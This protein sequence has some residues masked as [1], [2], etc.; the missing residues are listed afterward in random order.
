MRTILCPVDF[1]PFAENALVFADGLASLTGAKLLILH[2]FSMPEGS[3]PAESYF[4]PATSQAGIN[5][6][7][8]EITVPKL[9][10]IVQRLRQAH[11]KSGVQYEYLIRYGAATSEIR[12]VANEKKADLIVMG[13]SGANGLKELLEGTLTA[14]VA[15]NAHCPVL[16]VPQKAAYKSWKHI[17]FATDLESQFPAEVARVTELASLFQAQISFLHVVKEERVGED[18]RAKD[19]FNEISN[20]FN[21]SNVAF[22]TNENKNVE[23]GITRFMTQMKADLLVMSNHPRSAW[24]EL[25]KHSHTKEMAYHVQIPLLVIH[26]YAE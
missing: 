3:P 24:E 10:D 4:Q 15:E 26:A 5:L 19:Q 21:Y 9:E 12:R 14:N 2:V 11:D 23:E 25:F 16:V 20:M 6:E 13:T 1:S 17:L 22:F 7:V 8:E 18:D